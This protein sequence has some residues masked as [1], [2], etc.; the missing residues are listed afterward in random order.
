MILIDPTAA[1]LQRLEKDWKPIGGY[2]NPVVLERKRNEHMKE[3]VIVIRPLSIDFDKCSRLPNG[4][5]DEIDT[6]FKTVID[7]IEENSLKNRVKEVILPGGGPAPVPRP[8]KLYCNKEIGIDYHFVM[9]DSVVK[10]EDLV[11]INRF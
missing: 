6:F 8:F 4:L 2:S 11:N 9:Y 7:I 1:L 3:Y 5:Q 10:V